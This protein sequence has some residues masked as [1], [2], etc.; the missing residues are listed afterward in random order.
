MKSFRVILA[1]G[2][3]GG[4]VYPLIAVAESMQK[5]WADIRD[6]ELQL[7]YV[8]PEDEFTDALRSHDVI[9]RPIL[10]G[11]LRRYFSVQNLLDVP[12][13]FFG[14]IQALW[15]V[16]ALMPDVIFSKGGTGALP[17]VFAAWFYRIPIVIHESDSHPGLTNLVSSRFA[18]QVCVSFPDAAGYFGKHGAVVTGTPVRRELLEGRVTKD[19]AKE[20][21]GFSSRKPLVFVIGGSQGAQPINTFILENLKEMIGITQV[22]HQTGSANFSEVEKLAQ[23]VLIEASYENRYRAIGFLDD[24]TLRNALCAADLVISRAGSS[25]FEMASFGNAMILIPHEA[26]SNGHQRENAYA[27]SSHGA[28]LVIEE[29]NLLPGIFA[30]QLKK[31]LDDPALRQK[32]GEAAQKLCDSDAAANIVREI[33]KA[34]L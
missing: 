33:M 1:G 9:V 30:I 3:S 11:K 4:H 21:L 16:Y 12:R 18:R 26:G 24:A 6:N 27:F 10:S 32:M 8:G 34:T 22:L 31:L 28:A 13:F 2:G 23:V 17:V 7:F 19:A 14:M 5:L 20:T 15:R 29:P 25:I